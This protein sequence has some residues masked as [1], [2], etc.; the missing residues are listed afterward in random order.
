M[1]SK[2]NP[3]EPL[4]Y[5]GPE[6]ISCKGCKIDWK[7][8]KN[9]TVRKQ[10]HKMKGTKKTVTK[11]VKVNSFFNFFSPPQA[12]EDD[13]EDDE[14]KG[15][16]MLDY[17]IGETLKS[18]IIPRAVLYFTGEALE[19]DDDDDEFDDGDEDGDD[20]DENYNEDEDADYVPPKGAENG[21]PECKQQ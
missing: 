10:K 1:N 12:K 11:M 18:Q 7:A 17:E 15:L 3:D 2:P 20:E 8:D 16:L 5:E 9:V 4:A 14:T 13:D 19:G 6:I 21:P